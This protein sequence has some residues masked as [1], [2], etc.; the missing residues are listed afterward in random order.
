MGTATTT[1]RDATVRRV[2]RLNAA[3]T[4]RTV[5]PDSDLPW[6]ELGDGQL[7]P[8]ELL[9]TAGLGVDLDAPARRRLAHEEV[10]S[11]LAMG[12][13]FEAVLCAGFARMIAEAPSLADARITY[14]LYEVGEEAK[15]SRAFIRTIGELGPV[16][17][18]PIDGTPIPWLM[19]RISRWITRHDALLLV[20]TLAGEE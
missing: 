20:M 13:R 1:P 14:M 9:T 17:R 5:D 3:S 19:H 4:R 16:A 11:M 15:H 2:E 10:A 7:M 12:V 8:D 18:N 6:G